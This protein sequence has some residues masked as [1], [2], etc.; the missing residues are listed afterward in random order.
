MAHASPRARIARFGRYTLDLRSRELFKDGHKLRLQ[1]KPFRV[2][3]ALLERPGEL[4]SREDLRQRLWPADT[5][6]EFDHS[7]GN[8]LN[9]LRRTL[10]DS[11][12]TPR[13]IETLPRR[14]FRFIARVDLDVESDAAA[15]TGPP[16]EEAAVVGPTVADQQQPSRRWTPLVAVASAASLLLLV[17]VTW[18]I[19][20]PDAGPGNRGRRILVVLPIQNL[21]GDPAEDYFADGLTEEII[22]ELSRLNYEQ[23][24]VIART[25]SMRY[26][27]G[28]KSA[29]EIGRELKA[30]Y[31]LE[32]SVRREGD[33]LRIAAQLIETRNETHRWAE[34]FERDADAILTV[35][36]DIARAV[37][38]R[39][40]LT[41]TPERQT[42]LARAL[43]VDPDAYRAYLRGRYYWNKRTSEGFRKAIGEFN[44]SLAADPLFARAYA[45]LADAYYLLGFY[46]DM[47]FEEAMTSARSAAERAL[48]LD[49]NLA[50]AHTSLAVILAYFEWD[51]AGADREFRRALELDP[52]YPTGHHWY[53]IYLFDMARM[54]EA[55]REARR[56]VESDPLSVIITTDLAL[57]YYHARR[58]EEAVAQAKRALELEPDFAVAHYTLGR[59]YAENGQYP[60]ALT[61]LER[62][63]ALSDGN[64][65][66][67]GEL[68]RAYAAAG[69]PARTREIL[70]ELTAAADQRHVGPESF[71]VLHAALGEHDEAIAWLEQAYEHRSNFVISL[72]TVPSVDSLRGDPRFVELLRRAGLDS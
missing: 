69:N 16:A 31:L 70:A 49:L 10:N 72:K 60:E 66:F 56:A 41:L 33:R 67:M 32:G 52:S 34:A 48:E 45:G 59:A 20:R 65:L 51:F 64:P 5:F 27:G 19:A 43:T 9:R 63:V 39:I 7:L 12:E 23:L 25:T 28:G 46:T 30:D 62:A 6:V 24:G 8:A 37:A 42:Q 17:L 26:A 15:K 54:D 21:T 71:A 38:G 14:G 53:A 44:S 35:Q 58:Y 11:A 47:P 61:S 4:V 3:A 13:Y 1:D 68:G 2:L 50:E 36:R 18:G 22:S 57:T 29:A 40:E 55:V